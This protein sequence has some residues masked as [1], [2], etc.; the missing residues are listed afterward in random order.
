MFCARSLVSF[1][2]A[3]TSR[4]FG[5]DTAS[6]CFVSRYFALLLVFSLRSVYMP[7]TDFVRGLAG[8]DTSVCRA[9][10]SAWKANERANVRCDEVTYTPN[11]YAG[12]IATATRAIDSSRFDYRWLHHV[13]ALDSSPFRCRRAHR[14]WKRGNS[15]GAEIRRP[16]RKLLSAGTFTHL[17]LL[18]D[19]RRRTLVSAR[20]TIRRS[21]QPAFAISS[22]LSCKRSLDRAAM[23]RS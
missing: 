19:E 21:F 5:A 20:N 2:T 6:M 17:L 11:I 3:S 7:L 14:L 13:T 8:H 16:R 18:L 4:C 1:G 22:R 23:F 15:A 10:A 12:I 9:R